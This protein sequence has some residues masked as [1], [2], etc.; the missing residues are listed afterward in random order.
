M[1]AVYLAEAGRSL[2]VTDL[3]QRTLRVTVTGH[4]ARE[5]VETRGTGVTPPACHVVLTATNIVTGH[6]ARQAVVVR[7]TGVKQEYQ[8]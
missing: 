2:L 8:Q 1:R 4:T 7:G 5:A 6:T 3:R